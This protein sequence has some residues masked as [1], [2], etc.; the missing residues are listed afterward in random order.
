MLTL[1]LLMKLKPTVASEFSGSIENE[2]RSLLREQLGFGDEIALVAAERS[3]VA[4]ALE[5]C[6]R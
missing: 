3:E 5:D 2:S 1:H 4:A 6:L